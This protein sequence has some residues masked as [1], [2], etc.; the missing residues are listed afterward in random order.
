M[1]IG[2]GSR[3]GGVNTRKVS[4]RDMGIVASK[5]SLPKR[6]MKRSIR[7]LCL[8]VNWTPYKGDDSSSE[9]CDSE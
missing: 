2:D 7:I 6:E 5:L 4:V 9:S 1:L 8:H 3:M